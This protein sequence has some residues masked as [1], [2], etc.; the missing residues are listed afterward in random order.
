MNEFDA[1]RIATEIFYYLRKSSFNIGVNEYIAAL[2]AIRGGMGTGSLE[3]LKLILQLLWCHSLAE[4][5]QFSFIWQ[6]EA[7]LNKK[8]T[9]E[10]TKQVP[11]T[12]EVLETI[13]KT[14]PPQ[15]EQLSNLSSPQLTPELAPLPVRTPFV[16]AQIEDFPELRLYFPVTRRSLAYLWRY[17]RRP[18]ADGPLDVLDVEATVKQ[19]AQQGYYLAPVY[20]RREV[21]HAHL[22]LLLDQDGSM[23]PFHRFNRDL[24]ETAQE[25]STIE[26]VSTYYFHNVPAKYVYENSHLTTPVPLDQVLAECDSN[27]SVLIVSD[28]GAARGYRRMERIRA[29]TEFLVTIKQRTNLV[30]W[31]NPMPKERWENTSAEVI[32][33]LVLMEQMN[34]DGMSNAIDIVRGLTLT[35]TI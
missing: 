27:T 16:P 29:T 28:A 12:E 11:Q 32:A 1:E 31:L 33:Y 18:V 8:L 3:E 20:R 4:K 34:D 7:T 15:Q 9:T 26:I 25:D 24:V 23:T 21:N 13:E 22:L 35:L 6:S 10:I 17:L 2:D 5:S 14:L 19:V 30:C